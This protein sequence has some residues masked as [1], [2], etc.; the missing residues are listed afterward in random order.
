MKKNYVKPE[1]K[2]VKLHSRSQMLLG[3]P[4]AV[5]SVRSNDDVGLFYDGGGDGEAR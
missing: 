1:T 3:S 4:A 5:S 2:V